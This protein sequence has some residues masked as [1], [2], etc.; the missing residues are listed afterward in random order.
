VSND[1][2]HP[3]QFF[4]RGSIN[5]YDSG[6]GVLTAQ[7]PGMQHAWAENIRAVLRLAGHLQHG[8]ASGETLSD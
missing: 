1:G 3:G 5:L 4:R 2:L 8:V 7:N 6:V